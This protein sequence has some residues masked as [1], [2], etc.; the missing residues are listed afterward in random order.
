D[1]TIDAFDAA[2][3]RGADVVIVPAVH[4]AS[5]A[6]LIGWLKA[7]AAHGATL[8]GICDGVW[9]VAA[10]GALDGKRATGHWYSLRGLASKHPRTTWVRDRRYVRDGPVMTTTGVT[11][12]IPASLALVEEIAGTSRAE[13]VARRLGVH[14]WSA[15]HDSNLFSLSAR[16]AATAARNWLAF[17]S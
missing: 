2:H 11:A 13:D 1:E 4:D 14:G 9:A 10:T 8:V 12:S 17:W 7:Q 6:R 16:D 3:P 15:E 5:D